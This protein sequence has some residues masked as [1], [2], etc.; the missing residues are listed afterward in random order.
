MTR[1][2][3]I[4]WRRGALTPQFSAPYG[5]ER[6]EGTPSPTEKDD[7]RLSSGRQRDRLGLWGLRA[8]PLVWILLAA[9]SLTAG[10][11]DDVV[12]G[13]AY[14]VPPG[15]PRSSGYTAIECGLDGLIYVGTALY[16]EGCSLVRFSPQKESWETLWHL[17]TITGVPLKGINAQGKLHTKILIGTNGIVYAG[18]KRGREPAEKTKDDPD[19]SLYAG[20]YLLA[21]DPS[22][23]Q[24][25]NYGILKPGQGLMGG[26]MDTL[27]NLLYYWTYP[28]GELVSFD[29]NTRTTWISPA[30]VAQ[31][32]YT[33]IDPKGVVYM[34]G[35]SNTFVRFRPGEDQVEVLALDLPKGQPYQPPYTLILSP[36]GKE[37]V[38]L[39]LGGGSIQHYDIRNPKAKRLPVSYGPNCSPTNI[40]AND[41]HSAGLGKDGALY[42]T[43]TSRDI[44]YL[45]RYDIRK[46]KVSWIKR[47]VVSNRTDDHPIYSQGI[48]ASADGTLWVMCIYPLRIIGFPQLTKN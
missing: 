28:A 10:W 4:L 30:V 38:G 15:A 16:D 31:P 39:A 2:S 41:V 11:A 6:G 35:K 12:T 19:P 18:S 17:D 8:Q 23:G 37:M 25:T 46:R 42:Y 22:N 48:C 33:V 5:P 40:P 13:K 1:L 29:L 20:G 21:Y 24:T 47:M 32:R 27:R 9:F 45:A 44:P 14:V 34:T 3:L 36:D 43:V 7:S 26:S